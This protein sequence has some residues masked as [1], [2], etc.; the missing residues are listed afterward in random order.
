MPWIVH[1]KKPTK[2]L[3]KQFDKTGK[4]DLEEWREKFVNA[5]D[6]TEY[7]GAKAMGLTWEEWKRFK[8]NWP[9]FT[10]EILPKW[11]DEI[12]AKVKSDIFSNLMHNMQQNGD[13]QALKQLK[14]IFIDEE[15]PKKTANKKAVERIKEADVVVDTS[16]FSKYFKERDAVHKS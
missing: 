11:K 5:L 12:E 7:K 3:F 6:P 16:A 15:K 10:D 14:A 13:M 8:K 4:E 2:K 9:H 1:G